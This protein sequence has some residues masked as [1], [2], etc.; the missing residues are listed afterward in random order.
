MSVGVVVGDIMLDVFSRGAANRLSPEAP[1]PVLLNPT[2]TEVLGGA[3]NTAMNMAGLLGAEVSLV[4][5]LGQDPAGDACRRLMR[6]SGVLDRCVGSAVYPT[7]LKNR[8]QAGSHQIMRLDH[9]SD[10]V[11]P[12][13][14]AE[15]ITAFRESIAGARCAVVSD[16]QKAAVSA[17]VARE[18]IRTAREAG[19]P[20]VV[21]SKCRDF[22]R[23]EG[24]SA[25][26]PNHGEARDS[27]GHTDPSAAARALS[28]ATRGNVI[29]T[30]GPEGMLIHE[31][32][33]RQTRIASD[34]IEVADVTGAGDTVTAALAVALADGAE[35]VEAAR[36]ATRAAAIAVSRSG[37][38]AVSREEVEG[39]R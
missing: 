12:T 28:E 18:S 39:A 31:A 1:V 5:L 25:V 30:L 20:V 38:Y 9:E 32:S 11:G 7:V 27:T 2:T 16:Y 36:W 29:V 10:E 34:V 26:T 23:F 14:H 13:D 6:D 19:I 33:G 21:D 3:A 35:I 22:S 15:L 8:F 24:A 4:G 37:T 17:E